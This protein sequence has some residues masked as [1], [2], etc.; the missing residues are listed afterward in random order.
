MRRIFFSFFISVHRVKRGP[1]PVSW[2]SC[3]ND[4][5]SPTPLPHQLANQLGNMRQGLHRREIITVRG[6]SYVLRLPKYWPPPPPLSARRVCTPRPGPALV[7]G[8]ED[9]LAGWR[10]GWRVNILEDAR[11]SSVFYLYRI[12][13]GFHNKRIFKL[14]FPSIPAQQSM[15]ARNQVVVLARL[16]AQAGG[17]DSLE[18]ILGLLK[19]LKF[20]RCIYKIFFLGTTSSDFTPHDLQYSAGT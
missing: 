12:L 6:Q 9:T 14:P 3:N 18:S 17:T 1:W 19:S 4:I 13:F 15:G 11:H 8:G 2:N 20:G 10:G 16:A 7:A 5:D